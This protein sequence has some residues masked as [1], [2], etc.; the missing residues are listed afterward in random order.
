MT[1]PTGEPG[2]G[3]IPPPPLAPAVPS[4]PPSAPFGPP[5]P[6]GHGPY[7]EPGQSGFPPQQPYLQP[8]AQP[9]PQVLPQAFPQAFPPAAGGGVGG[10]G[11][12]RK[13]V[14]G[15][16]VAV[17][18]IVAAGAGF[19]V[20]RAT[21]PDAHQERAA[22]TP[23]PAASAPVPGPGSGA[24]GKP[25]PSASPSAGSGSLGRALYGT[26]VKPPADAGPLPVKSAPDGVYP[27]LS[28]FVSANFADK[29][30]TSVLSGFGYQVSAQRNW[31][32]G[33]EEFHVQLVQ[34]QDESGAQNYLQQ[35]EYAYGQDST[36][37]KHGTVSG[38]SGAMEFDRKTLDSAGNR[39]SFLCDAVGRVFV[40]VEAFTPGVVDRSADSA[41]L[42]RQVS[43]LSATV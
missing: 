15:V 20:G 3:P 5:P 7:A 17:A 6:W 34:F 16:V 27:S 10:A 4:P 8:S 31:T 11:G 36:V 24:A 13:A 18:V 43:H 26:I 37:T 41:L 29:G 23:S 40:F 22:A 38:V 19:G 2:F 28:A 12:S 32:V 42:A 30:V 9:Y 33:K 25:S 21:A 35:Q 1:E 14:L 39:R